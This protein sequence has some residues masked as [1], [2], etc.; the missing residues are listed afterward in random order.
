M[1]IKK[2]LY[3]TTYIL[4][5]VIF[6]F[7]FSPIV[8][9]ELFKMDLSNVNITLRYK[10][11]EFNT[12]V[13]YIEE[14][15]VHSDFFNDIY[16]YFPSL[17]DLF[18]D[19]PE[20]V[21]APVT[22][23]LLFIIFII[24]FMPVYLYLSYKRK[25]RVLYERKEKKSH[26][27]WAGVL[28][29]V[30]CV[31]ITSVVLTPINGF[32]R[33][34]HTAIEDTLDDEYHSLCEEIGSLEK[35]S[36]YCNLIDVYDSTIFAGLGG[37]NTPNGYVFDALTRISYEDGYTSIA[38]EA[39]LIMKSS[40]V[41]DQSGLLDGIYAGND[42]IPTELIISNNLS[43]R[44]IDIIVET[45]SNSKY[46]QDL[47]VELRDLVFN[48]LESLFEE[49]FRDDEIPI[50]Y[51]MTNEEVVSEIKVVLKAI[52]A[53]KGTNFISE[54]LTIKEIIVDFAENYP[55]YKL[56]D[57]GVYEFID[58]LVN[59]I[60][61]DD[62]EAFCEYFFESKLISSTLPYI[63]NKFLGIFGFNFSYVNS[64]MLEIIKCFIEF[65]RMVKNHKAADFFDLF[66]QF[67]D[68]ELAV[69]GSLGQ[70]VSD[71]KESTAFID[72]IFEHAFQDFDVHPMEVIYSVEDWGKEMK[73]LREVFSIINTY[74][75]TG[76]LNV[77]RILRLLEKKKNSK[78]GELFYEIVINNIP[79]FF[80]SIISGESAL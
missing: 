15:V 54:I 22:Y 58:E 32:N 55:L 13:D 37:G 51:S 34:Y 5:S 39:S 11:Q 48:T 29:C 64:E 28:G 19:F 26:R 63:A 65:G 68:K 77:N 43:D 38:K 4:L 16:K 74:N 67:S 25:R 73:D 79:F 62:L 9:N 30:Q 45:I 3:R 36:K 6:A 53:L 44:D 7:I 2:A 20:V 40:I 57:V 41:L 14:V 33:I 35:Y 12:I 56:D 31:F 80:E 1:G 46:S 47:L 76:N 23:V 27:I 21:L 49:F 17:K 10:D 61:L 59:A 24:V 8:N 72:F 78:V 60:N 75:Q 52:K 70:R 18:M 69:L 42:I 71:S 66:S 50:D